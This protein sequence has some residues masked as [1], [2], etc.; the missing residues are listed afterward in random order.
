MAEDALVAKGAQVR[1]MMMMMM[2]GQVV[3]LINLIM[4]ILL[5]PFLLLKIIIIIITTRSSSLP[6]VEMTICMGSLWQGEAGKSEE[7]EGEEE[8]EV[9]YDDS[10][11]LKY[12]CGGDGEF[13]PRM[14][15]Q[16]LGRIRDQRVNE[17]ISSRESH[18]VSEMANLTRA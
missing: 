15:H 14:P 8:V 1:A 4:V 10:T 7:E 16:A 3:R 9:D 18:Q 2:I 17:S 12:V 5:L 13:P 11:V 6:A